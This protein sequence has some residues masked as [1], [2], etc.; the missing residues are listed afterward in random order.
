MTPD[1]DTRLAASWDAIVGEISA[2]PRSRF[3]R[4]LIRCRVPEPT[5]RLVA[6]TPALRWSWLLAVLVVLWFAAA[7]GAEQWQRGDQLAVFLSLAPVVPVL[8]VALAYGGRA[9]RA[10][11]VSVAAPL[12]GLRLLLLRSVT[13]VGAA[14]LL[15][16]ITVLSAPTTG[17]LRLA[18]LAPALATTALTLA[19]STAFDVRRAALGVSV[20]WLAVVTL[21]AQIADDATAPFGAVGQL[22]AALLAIG[23]AALLLVRR[24]R[25]D[26]WD[27][28]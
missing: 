9:D 20:A 10:H 19:L 22:A 2:P 24:R 21:V 18:W 4:A 13:V 15:T 5:A 1:L 27:A 17:L 25:L 12:S 23:A 3:E 6:A 8:G 11:E 26:R 16:L 28:A 14:V 7:A